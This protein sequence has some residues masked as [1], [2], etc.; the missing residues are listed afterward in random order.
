MAWLWTYSPIV[1]LAPIFLRKVGPSKFETC[2]F[3]IHRFRHPIIGE[4]DYLVNRLYSPGALG[5]CTKVLI[6]AQRQKI[7]HD[8]VDRFVG[9]RQ[10]FLSAI[11]FSLFFLQSPGKL[12]F[13]DLNSS[14]IPHAGTMPR[15]DCGADAFGNSLAFTVA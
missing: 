4:R 1:F 14:G 10:R 13:G 7:T 15:C 6:R 11:R 9:R 3:A 12:P 2:S 8:V 5:R